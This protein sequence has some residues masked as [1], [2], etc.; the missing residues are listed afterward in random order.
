MVDEIYNE[1]VTEHKPLSTKLK[2][3]GFDENTFMVI[4]KYDKLDV[5]DYDE[6]GHLKKSEYLSFDPQKYSRLNND[7][8][9]K[10]EFDRMDE[11]IEKSQGGKIPAGGL[12]SDNGI[13]TA[14][15]FHGGEMII[16]KDP[17]IYYALRDKLRFAEDVI[18]TPLSGSGKL[19][20]PK[21]AMNFE[22]MEYNC[23]VKK[24]RAG[25]KDRTAAVQRGD[26]ITTYDPNNMD[27]DGCFRN[28]RHYEQQEDGGLK[29]VS[30]EYVY[31]KL[32]LKMQ[33]SSNNSAEINK[34]QK[35]DGQVVSKMIQDKA[36][37]Y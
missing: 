15:A 32:H 14:K 12:G 7:N 9:Y 27:S 25:E 4:G 31:A 5:G 18:D 8:F 26:I 2:E 22:K 21:Q 16:T 37:Y 17:E 3:M 29:P 30:R 1:L 10:T 36:K 33:S 34:G 6:T 23:K 35:L 28:V 19:M 24:D 13:Y 11:A 20:D